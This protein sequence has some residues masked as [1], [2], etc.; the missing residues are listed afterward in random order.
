MNKSV[1]EIFCVRFTLLPILILYS[2]LNNLKVTDFTSDKA[3]DVFMYL[4]MLNRLT[5]F[6]CQLEQDICMIYNAVTGARQNIVTL[7]VPIKILP[8][9]NQHASNF[10]QSRRL[11]KHRPG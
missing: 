8:Q 2:S 11:R 1:G 5:R 9:K 4:Q 10:A 7:S 3:A 6:H